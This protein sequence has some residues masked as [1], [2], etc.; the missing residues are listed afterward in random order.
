MDGVNIQKKW[1]EVLKELEEKISKPTVKTWFSNVRPIQIIDGVLKLEVPSKLVKNWIT[2]KFNIILLKTLKEKIGDIKSI[3]YEVSLDKVTKK[4]IRRRV[5][6]Q[7]KISI[8]EVNPSTNLNPRYRFDNFVVGSNNEL[9]FAAAEGV[10]NNL[11]SYINPLFIYGGV[12][13]GKTHLLQA[14]GNEVY[15]KYSGTKKIRYATTEQFTNELI[16]SLRNQTIDEFRKKFRDVDL[17]IL[18]D[19]HFISGK[20][21]TQ[22]ELFHTFNEL[23]NLKKQIVFSSDRPPRMIKDIEERLQSRFEGGLIIDIIPPD[24]ETRLAILK[25]KNQERGYYLKDDILELIAQKITKNI[26]ELEGCLNYLMFK[27]KYTQN[28]TDSKVEQMIK[29]YLQSN[30]KKVSYKTIIKKVAE[31]YNLKEEDILKRARRKDLSKPRQIVMY[32]L[33]EVGKLSYTRIGEILN[34]RDHTTALYSYEKI[35]KEIQEDFDLSQEIEVLK[36]RILEG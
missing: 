22:E 29:E 8:F 9:A 19:V 14:I 15:R 3:E 5:V 18:D 10:V 35:T 12:G 13:L 2:T 26:R 32:L 16:N 25:M 36:Q 6:Y 4:T 24:F 11:G 28:P 31:F 33:R 20:T 17:L 23:F 30:I 1:E 34:N 7:Q 21:K 27:L